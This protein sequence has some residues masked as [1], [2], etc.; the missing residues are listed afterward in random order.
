VDDT[1]WVDEATA[2]KAF[3]EVVTRGNDLAERM[4]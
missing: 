4:L 1:D 2:R 3:G